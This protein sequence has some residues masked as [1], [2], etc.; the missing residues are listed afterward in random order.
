[1]STQALVPMPAMTPIVRRVRAYFAPVARA[2]NTPTAFDAAVT[3]G[4][5][6][7]APPQPWLDLGWVEGFT[8][9]SQSV[10]AGVHSGAPA[11]ARSQV[12]QTL[13]ATVA[14][15]FKNWGKLQLALCAGSEHLNVLAE[16]A[17]AI[18]APVPVV[19]AGSSASFV[20]L[21]TGQTAGFAAGQI[22][23][24]DVDYAGQTGFVG[25]GSAGAY[26]QQA[27]LVAQ[28]AN[29]VRRISLNVGRVTAVTANGLQL[30]QP[31]LAGVPVTGMQAQPVCGFVDREGGNFFQEWSALFVMAGEQGERVFF[32]YPRLQTM[33][34]ASEAVEAMTTSAGNAGNSLSSL[35]LQ[36]KF[37]A[38]PVTDATDGQQALCYRIFTPAATTLLR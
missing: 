31:L 19:A 26:V 32:Y 27:S 2:S 6:L 38:M 23:V 10:F 35:A 30:A 5:N 17:G 22:V 1:M 4:F 24:V 14:L 33:T 37:R 9:S 11:A 16:N 21:G 8:R 29:Y 18:V 28:D 25:S 34:G 7:D 36:G 13:D 20:A 3:A 15:R 12:R